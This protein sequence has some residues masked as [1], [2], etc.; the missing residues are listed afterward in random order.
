MHRKTTS[1]WTSIVTLLAGNETREPAGTRSRRRT[2]M[3]S[4]RYAGASTSAI[5]R[6][7]DRP[8]L[9]T[10]I[11]S[12]R[13]ALTGCYGYQLWNAKKARHDGI[14]AL[15]GR[16]IARGD[17]VFSPKPGQAHPGNS[18]AMIAAITG[19]VAQQPRRD[20]IQVS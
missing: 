6:I 10:L 1:A 5:V 7:V 18:D 14:C 20:G 16:H 17:A 19:Q 13:D 4:R 3:G 9:R 15:T 12:W 8:T 2:S 11:V